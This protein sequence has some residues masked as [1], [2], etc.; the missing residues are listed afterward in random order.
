MHGAGGD[1]EEWK[2]TPIPLEEDQ[3]EVKIECC[4][5][6]HSDLHQAKSRACDSSSSDL[7]GMIGA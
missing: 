1:V 2:Y 3:V 4:G 6:C 7:L 5:V